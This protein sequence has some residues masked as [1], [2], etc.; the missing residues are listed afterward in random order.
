MADLTDIFLN[1]EYITKKV[2]EKKLLQV[3]DDLN[4]EAKKESDYEY[5]IREKGKYEYI[6]IDLPNREDFRETLGDDNLGAISQMDYKL[7][8]ASISSLLIPF[9]KAIM[10]AFPGMLV[11]GLT[12]EKYLEIQAQE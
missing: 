9:T 7:S 5:L 2:F 10:E 3:C 8:H 11:D 1:K 6:S 12:L 4:L